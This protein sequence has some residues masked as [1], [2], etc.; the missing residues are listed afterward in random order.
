MPTIKVKNIGVN[1]F[2]GFTPYGNLTTLRAKL[3]TDATGAVIGSNSTAPVALGD[4]VVLQSLPAGMLLEDAQVIVSTAMTATVTGSLGFEYA[5]G[6]DDATVPQDAA[7]FGAGLV[8][9]A[10]GRLRCAT[11]KAPVTLA[12]EAFLVL[13]TAGAANAKASRVDFIVHG[14][15]L[16]AK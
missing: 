11:A 7:Y 10:T 6:V 5:D 1:Q 12:K 4:K 8:L 2:G 3:V 9:N 15:R 14:E 13:T 16:G